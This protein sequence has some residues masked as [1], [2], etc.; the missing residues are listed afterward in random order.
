VIAG[1]DAVVIDFGGRQNGYCS[2]T[3]R[4]FVVGQASARIAEVHAVVAD[5]HRAAATFARRG[6]QASAV[7]ARARQ[8]I[9][10]AGYGEFFIHRLGHGI[11]L[12]GHEPPYLVEG[13][14]AT[15]APGH[16]FSIEP[17]IY[18]PGEFGVRI[19]DIAVIEAD[20]ELCVLNGSD[21]SLIE[22]E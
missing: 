4:T 8:V 7:D 17:G 10:D 22:V 3:T 6:V 9:D 12:E 16:A 18:L 19:E 1:G 14:S 15:L 11:G 2:D 21:R 5:A 20:G 13:E